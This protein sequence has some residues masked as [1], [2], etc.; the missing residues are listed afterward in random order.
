MNKTLIAIAMAV[1]AGFTGLVPRANAATGD[2]LNFNM[3]PSAGAI[4]LA[5]N[6]RARV[7]LT[8]LGSVQKMHIEAFGL[9]PNTSFTA[10]I[11]QHGARPFGVSWYQGEIQTDSRGR[12]VAD[13]AGIFSDETFVLTDVPVKL[14]HMG[15]WF[16]DPMDAAKAGCSD[17][18]TPF[19]G[20]G[21]GGILVLSTSNFADD[22]GPLQRLK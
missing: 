13:F 14:A 18:S 19:D 12:G 5:S 11:T 9:V 8:D 15:V 16:A 6:A 21:E 17:I 1:A 20:D 22:R 4:C 7:T 10:F 2:T 3:V